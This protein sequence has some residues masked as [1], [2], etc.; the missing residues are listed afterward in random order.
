M[1]MSKELVTA[2]SVAEEALNNLLEA[3]E[4]MGALAGPPSCDGPLGQL[5]QSWLFS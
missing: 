1:R 4:K 3:L 2:L 5:S